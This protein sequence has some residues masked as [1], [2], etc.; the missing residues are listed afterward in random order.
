VARP[1][2]RPSIAR[3]R[4]EQGRLF[5]VWLLTLPILLLI[6]ASR[7]FGAPWPNQLTQRIGF[8]VLAFPVLFVVGEPLFSGA[9][10][11]IRERRADLPLCVAAAAAAGY[12]SGVLA[13]FTPAPP[14]AGISALMVSIYLSLRY[15][16]SRY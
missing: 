5:W 9:I 12:A 2:R 15:I 6:G 1:R 16:T 14:L 3:K 7:A 4:E 8:V 13:I 11:S 10:A